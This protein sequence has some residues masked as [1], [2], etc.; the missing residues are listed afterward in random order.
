VEHV[1]PLL[2][3]AFGEGGA[4]AWVAADDD[5]ALPC[6]DF[7]ESHGVRVPDDISVAGFDDSLDGFMRGL[8][9]YNYVGPAYVRA[10]LRHV[11]SPGSPESGGSGNCPVELPG[12]V[13]PRHTTGPARRSPHSLSP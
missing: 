3:A 9:T 12:V 1:L 13:V 11:L 6:L 8:T 10:M 7:L 2:Q 5:T 4:T